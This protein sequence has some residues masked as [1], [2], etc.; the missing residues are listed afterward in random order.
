MAYN[1]WTCD[2][3]CAIGMVFEYQKMYSCA[4]EMV[5]CVEAKTYFFFRKNH[6]H[7]EG[8]CVEEWKETI[9]SRT[10]T[11]GIQ[12]SDYLISNMS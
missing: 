9:M 7:H 4:I 11:K 5:R 6:H 2:I 10:C 1:F 8:R 3:S 12:Y